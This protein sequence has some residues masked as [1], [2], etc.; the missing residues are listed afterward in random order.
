MRSW[1]KDLCCFLFSFLR[2]VIP[3][4][5]LR[6]LETDLELERLFKA[7]RLSPSLSAEDTVIQRGKVATQLVR[8]QDKTNTHVPD[9]QASFPFLII[10]FG[11]LS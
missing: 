7:P 8:G 4:Q 9:P 5:Q 6:L 11:P 3:G 2:E 10:P 1:E